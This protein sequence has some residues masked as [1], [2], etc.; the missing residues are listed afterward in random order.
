MNR[1]GNPD[2]GCSVLRLNLTGDDSKA[3]FIIGLNRGIRRDLILIL[4]AVCPIG[5]RRRIA[6][7]SH[8]GTGTGRT[9]WTGD[10]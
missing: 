5:L 8:D 1:D 7:D 10:G 3:F 9:Y 6:G 4:F 2:Q